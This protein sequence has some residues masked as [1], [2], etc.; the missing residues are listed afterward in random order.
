MIKTSTTYTEEIFNDFV[1]FNSKK[2]VKK[3]LGICSAIIIFCSILMFTTG[4]Y[5]LGILYACLGVFLALFNVMLRKII[6]RIY[7]KS[8][9]TTS[10]FEFDENSFNVTVCNKD[11][12]EISNSTISYEILYGIKTYKNYA[13]IFG[14]K[15]NAY[16]LIKENFESENEFYSLLGKISSKIKNPTNTYNPEINGRNIT[17]EDNSQENKNTNK[18]DYKIDNTI[19]ESINNESDIVLD[20]KDDIEENLSKDEDLSKDTEQEENAIISKIKAKNAS[21]KKSNNKKY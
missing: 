19:N 16:I 18:E 2:N 6:I 4:D 5:P 14:N 11:G 10:T 21:I 1:N 17:A 12:N 8:L 7:K 13:Y 15:L 20:T 9:N 3:V